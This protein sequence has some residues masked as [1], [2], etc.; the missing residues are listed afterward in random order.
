MKQKS[1]SKTSLTSSKLTT[2][3]ERNLNVLTTE[4][5]TVAAI[6]AELAALD[7]E[8]VTRRAMLDADHKAGCQRL[9]VEISNRRMACKRLLAVLQAEAGKPEEK[10]A[11]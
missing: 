6:T 4:T 11:E 7:G 9:R 2:L 10:A 5:L 8:Y 3:T 1:Y